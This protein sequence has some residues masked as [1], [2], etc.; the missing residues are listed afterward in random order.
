MTLPETSA[1]LRS[2]PK[3]Y[4]ETYLERR[5]EELCELARLEGYVIT[6]Q[7][8]PFG[9]FAMGNTIMIPNVRRARG[10]Y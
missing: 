3:G 7:E 4:A 5:L 10:R 2:M 9:D 8:K 1:L 6:V